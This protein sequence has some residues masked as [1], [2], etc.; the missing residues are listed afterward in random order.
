MNAYD[1]E[2]ALESLVLTVSKDGGETSEAVNLKASDGVI[3]KE[4]L[5]KFTPDATGV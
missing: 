5:Y 3:E 4:T 1:N 2:T